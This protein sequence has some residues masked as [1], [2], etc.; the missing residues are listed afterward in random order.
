MTGPRKGV[1]SPLRQEKRA[2]A[3]SLVA[4]PPKG[5]LALWW[6]AFSSPAASDSPEALKPRE[7]DQGLGPQPRSRPRGGTGPWQ[8]VA[9]GP[10]MGHHMWPQKVLMNPPRSTQRP[11]V[12]LPRGDRGEG[13]PPVPCTAKVG[14]KKCGKHRCC[15]VG[16]PGFNPPL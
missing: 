15:P 11:G 13:A 12:P 3:P 16:T 10:W 4:F 6:V 8:A 1:R 5:V 2:A 14:G 7:P 9:A